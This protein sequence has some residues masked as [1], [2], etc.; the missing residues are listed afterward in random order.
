MQIHHNNAHRRDDKEHRHVQEHV[1]EHCRPRT[2]IDRMRRKIN[3]NRFL[4][5]LSDAE[6]IE[7]QGVRRSLLDLLPAPDAHRQEVCHA[8]MFA[9]SGTKH[10]ALWC[11]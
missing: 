9:L 11:F 7:L 6:D 3:H 8:N 2:Y 10:E 1:L 5:G 4:R